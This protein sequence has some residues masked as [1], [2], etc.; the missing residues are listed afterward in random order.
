MWKSSQEQNYNQTKLK[1]YNMTT[2]QLQTLI[3][4]SGHESELIN[5]I[6]HVSINGFNAMFQLTGE[7]LNIQV[8][9]AEEAEIVNPSEY[10]IAAMNQNTLI[11]P[12]SFG[13]FG[14]DDGVEDGYYALVNSVLIEDID[15]NTI[16]HTIVSIKRALSSAVKV[17]SVGLNPDTK[18]KKLAT[19]QRVHHNLDLDRSDCNDIVYQLCELYLLDMIV[20]YTPYAEYSDQESTEEEYDDVDHTEAIAEVNS[21]EDFTKSAITP[22]YSEPDYSDDDTN[23]YSS[24]GG[25]ESSYDSGGSDSSSSSFD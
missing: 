11:A 7:T 21:E 12:F 4:E 6:V 23:R 24:G 14:T 17:L 1:Y 16:T 5:N 25:Y 19:I 10:A 9:L 15:V 8:F 20:D 2:E 3:T 13:Y 18:R 22:S